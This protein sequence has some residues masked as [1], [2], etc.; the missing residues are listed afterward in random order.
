MSGADVFDKVAS[1]VAPFKSLMRLSPETAAYF[2][3]ILGRYSK[4]LEDA[5]V[6]LSV[7][8]ENVA[9]PDGRRL[10]RLS[11]EFS[12]APLGGSPKEVFEGTKWSLPRELDIRQIL[13]ATS[14]AKCLEDATRY[15]GKAVSDM[16]APKAEPPKAEPEAGPSGSS[17]GSPSGEGSPKAEGA[18]VPLGEGT[19]PESGEKSKGSKGGS[20]GSGR[21]R[22]KRTGAMH[23]N[24]KRTAAEQAEKEQ[25]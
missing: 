6:S 13:E 1:S 7:H 4:C 24:Q 10:S 14:Q 20:K 21:R 18:D 5:G 25:A 23:A 9:T 17:G 3:A 11:F 15:I 12:K 2:M 16:E 19:P 22:S 8:A